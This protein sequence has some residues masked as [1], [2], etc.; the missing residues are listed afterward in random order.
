MINV[1]LF[2]AFNCLLI[3]LLILYLFCNFGSL[4]NVIIAYNKYFFPNVPVMCAVCMHVGL[5]F[6]HYD[7]ASPL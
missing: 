1:I 6:C 5:Q 3:N 4:I 2:C 7:S